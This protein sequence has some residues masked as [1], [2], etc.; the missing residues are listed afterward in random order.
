MAPPSS[1]IGPIADADREAIRK[2][3]LG[4][5]GHYEQTVDRESAYEKLKA[6]TEAR[7]GGAGEAG[8]AGGVGTTPPAPSPSAG[9]GLS[10]ALS[11]ILLGSTGPRGGRREGMIEAAAKSA[12]RSVGS[13]F[14]RAILRG[15]LGGIF[16]GSSRRR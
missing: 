4:I 2:R 13:S 12:A 16:G 14:G 9:G 5:Y 15:T 10:D 7:A 1:Q 11:N 8:A 6:R 3:S